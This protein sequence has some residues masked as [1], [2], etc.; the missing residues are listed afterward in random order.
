MTQATHASE[1][2]R[3]Y[4]GVFIARILIAL[5]QAVALYWLI[6]AMDEPRAWPATSAS[7]YFPLLLCAAFVPFVLTI[8]LGQAPWR[9]LSIWALVCAL[10]CALLGWHDATRGGVAPN[11][12]TDS[13]V[14]PSV[15]LCVALSLWLFV[16]QVLAVDSINERKF[17]PPFAVHFDTAWKQGA[18]IALALGFVGVFWGVLVLGAGLFKLI[19]LTFFLRLITDRWF[20]IPA[21]TLA[22][23]LAFHV[24]DVQP[25]M[26]RGV[27]ELALTLLSWA[28]PLLAII[29]AGFLACLPFISLNA[30]WRTHFAETMLLMSAAVLIVL[31]NT[32]YQDGANDRPKSRIKRAAASL[33]ALELTPIVALAAW[34]MLLR[35]RQ[36]GWTVSRVEVAAV[37]VIAA[38]HALGYALA[39]F[40]SPTWLKRLEI[41]NIASAYL[42]LATVLALFTPIADPSRLMVADQLARLKSGAVA[43]SQFDFAALKFD[44]A[45]WGADALGQL[46]KM[47]DGA[48]AQAIQTGAAK[49]IAMTSRYGA[50]A[51]AGIAETNIDAMARLIK[52]VPAGRTLP[53]SF[54]HWVADNSAKAVDRFDPAA[55][56]RGLRPT[57]CVAASVTL[58]AGGKESIILF[59]GTDARVFGQ[60]DGGEWGQSRAPTGAVMLYCPDV[61]QAI[62]RGEIATDPHPDPDLMIAGQRFVL[63][64][65]SNPRL[66]CAPA[67]K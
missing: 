12:L 3:P 5:A 23:A 18:Q 63:A 33:G 15:S 24:A 41:T 32:C 38:A 66:P 10:V 49:A 9:P 52:V 6:G 14:W 65:S 27:R 36:Y 55:C 8:G 60:N 25:A 51:D 21:T 30:L 40:V 1:T 16:A 54:Y 11:Y 20:A 64:P 58:A 28:M 67:A 56:F 48:D 43:P 44:G 31:I 2:G 46:S 17:A 26:I 39:V 62:E 53:A 4:D 34:A 50:S 59:D 57:P 22:F 13:G 42:A 35:T 37:V 29:L 19:D 61:R 7:L 45:R 47:N